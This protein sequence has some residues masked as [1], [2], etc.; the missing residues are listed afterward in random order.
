M[1]FLILNTRLVIT[2]CC[3]PEHADTLLPGIPTGAEH[4]LNFA[5][6]CESFAGLPLTPKSLL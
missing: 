3:L 5:T 6:F 2:H 1:Y 4:L